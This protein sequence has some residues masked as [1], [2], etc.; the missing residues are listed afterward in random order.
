M[1][2]CDKCGA[3]L[4][5]GERF[6]KS[7]GHDLSAAG[8]APAAPPTA[9]APVAFP[10][11]PPGASYPQYY[12]APAPIPVATTPARRKMPT[13]IRVLVF[14][15]GIVAIWSGLRSLG[16]V[17][18]P[19]KMV[20]QLQ[21]PAG[22]ANAALVQQQVFSSPWNVTNGDVQLSNPKWNN[23]SNVTIQS[24][25]LEC[26]QYDGNNTDLAQKH[27]TLA[28]TNGPALPAQNIEEFNSLDIGQAVQ[29]LAKVNCGIVA[30]TPAQ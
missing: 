2:F 26:D 18:W 29:G 15:V 3:Q 20:G 25:D 7:C 17:T 8:A 9:A 5:G 6:C 23:R 27:L 28:G 13:P 1:A 19:T 12:S 24:V 4:E 30:A 21:P 16:I 22:V 14:L 11:A 10:S